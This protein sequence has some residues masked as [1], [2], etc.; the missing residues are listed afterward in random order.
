M[1]RAMR[2]HLALI[3][4]VVACGGTETPTTTATIP[5]VAPPDAAVA[6]E[7]PPTAPLTPGG[8]FE[9]VMKSMKDGTTEA[10]VTAPAPGPEGTGPVDEAMGDE[11]GDEG[12]EPEA[13]T[14]EG[15]S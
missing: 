12:D 1:M 11:G 2:A 10:E 9:W 14:H 3:L 8:Q 15:A 6:S 13:A 7:P 4:L 5:I